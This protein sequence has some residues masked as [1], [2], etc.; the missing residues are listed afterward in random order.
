MNYML[1]IY[2]DE[3]SL[4][5]PTD[6]DGQSVKTCDGLV[7]RLASSGQYVAS[8]ILQPT[9]SATSVRL[10]DGNRLLTDG[11]FA[12]TREQLAGYLLIDAADLDQ[13][14][15]VAMQHPVVKTGTVEIRPVREI[16]VPAPS[17]SATTV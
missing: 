16:P 5:Q 15:A 2:Q 4:N 17:A 3:N 6:A 11:P 10:R 8:G 13:A 14:I 1:L 7:D 12:E 9:A